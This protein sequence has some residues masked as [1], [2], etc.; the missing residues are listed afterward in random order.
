MPGEGKGGGAIVFTPIVGG[1]DG[2]KVFGIDGAAGC[3][4]GDR[5][6]LGLVGENVFCCP[7]KLFGLLN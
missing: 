5:L 3:R 6:W 4:L 2:V 7:A 1:C